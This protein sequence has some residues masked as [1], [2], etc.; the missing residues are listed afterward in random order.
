[1]KSKKEKMTKSNKDTIIL[2]YKKQRLDCILTIMGLILRARSQTFPTARPFC[3]INSISQEITKDT[4]IGGYAITQ[5]KSV[6]IHST[7]EQIIAEVLVDGPT[8][9][10]RRIKVVSRQPLVDTSVF[11]GDGMVYNYFEISTR[12]YCI[13]YETS[14]TQNRILCFN[15]QKVNELSPPYHRFMESMSDSN[16]M[17]VDIQKVDSYINPDII[18][19]AYRSRKKLI[20]KDFMPPMSGDHGYSGGRNEVRFTNQLDEVTTFTPNYLNPDY[21]F[22][23]RSYESD[24]TVCRLSINGGPVN[25]NSAFC[26]TLNGLPQGPPHKHK[27]IQMEENSQMLYFSYLDNTNT[28]HIVV[29]RVFSSSFTKMREI[30]FPYEFKYMK[31]ISYKT[32][33]NRILMNYGPG[34]LMIISHDIAT[35]TFFTPHYPGIGDGLA[36]TKVYFNRIE[37]T[38]VSY[39][40]ISGANAIYTVDLE[41]LDEPRIMRNLYR[42]D[43]VNHNIQYLKRVS[44]KQI[45]LQT[46]LGFCKLI[47]QNAFSD[48]ESYMFTHCDVTWPMIFI[49]VSPANLL[50]GLFYNYID[51][52]LYSR[53]LDTRSETYN[54]HG[55][56]NP[57]C[58]AQTRINPSHRKVVR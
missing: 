8:E 2:S 51:K 27:I 34:S 6:Q 44:V 29:Y 24:H 43:V 50:D 58:F 16:D 13:S 22:F 15:K 9:F 47:T 33:V 45:F 36:N 42:V 1:M 35:D 5:T 52:K 41:N 31:V 11:G 23:M 54:E 19:L 17:I 40:Y 38:S 39:Y 49:A 25:A 3:L 48:F 37:G 28:N 4:L 20:I 53:R 46:H 12:H 55:T 10:Q 18:R 26:I 57:N 32:D 30:Q 7:G 14:S 56:N 21:I